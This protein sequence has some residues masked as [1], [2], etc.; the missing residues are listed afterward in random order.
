MW[1]EGGHPSS[2]LKSVQAVR[3]CKSCGRRFD[4]R[5]KASE[6]SSSAGRV[7]AALAVVATLLRAPE[8]YWAVV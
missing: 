1:H 5:L 2:L 7:C 4:R 3:R 8:P 6:A